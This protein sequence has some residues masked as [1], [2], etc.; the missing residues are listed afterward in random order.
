MVDTN[1]IDKNTNSIDKRREREKLEKEI[2]AYLKSG[3]KIKRIPEG[4]GEFE[5]NQPS[6]IKRRLWKED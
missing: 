4:V 6:I 1:Y 2:Q 5:T 3:K